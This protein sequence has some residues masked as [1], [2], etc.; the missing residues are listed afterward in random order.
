MDRR[1]F[2]KLSGTAGL[3]LGLTPAMTSLAYGRERYDG[4]FWVFVHASGGW[5]PTLLCDPKGALSEADPDPVNRFLASEIVEA[6]PFRLPPLDFVLEFFDR[7]GDD[8]L[9]MNG[10]DTGTNSHSVG[11]RHVWSGSTDPTQPSLGALVAGTLPEPPSL[12]YLANGGYTE[13]AGLVANTRLTDTEDLLAL[14]WPERLDPGNEGSALFGPATTARLAAARDVRLAALLDRTTLPRQ[15]RAMQVLR[16][17]RSLDNELRDLAD[18]LPDDLANGGLE[19]QAQVAMACFKSGVSACASLALGGFDTHGDH[20]NRHTP[21]MQQLLAGVEFVVDEAER[22]GLADRVIVVV[23]SDFAR[24]PGF[25]SGNGKDHWPVT[26]MLAM[27]PGIVGGRVVGASDERQRA[28]TIDPESLQLDEDGVRLTPGHVHAAL[29]ELAGIDGHEDALL[30]A[31]G[32]RLP[33][34]L[35]G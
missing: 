8:L 5:D 22:Q 16:E 18:A 10:L 27:G 17:A 34:L 32:E 4:P 19:A 14:A 26:S 23:G 35:E 9:V 31:V 30:H 11:T 1:T 12:A 25:N 2:L 24:T 29:R 21:R 6:G 7:F 33:R 3:T 28:R 13:A 20:D 15:R